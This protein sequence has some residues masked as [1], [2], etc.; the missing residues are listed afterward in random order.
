MLRVREKRIEESGSGRKG[1][2]ERVRE[3]ERGG[4]GGSGG[5][6]VRGEGVRGLDDW[7][8]KKRRESGKGEMMER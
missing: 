3:R 2:R 7:R 4:E 5:V 1:E 6:K 8:G